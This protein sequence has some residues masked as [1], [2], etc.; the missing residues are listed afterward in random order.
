MNCYCIENNDK[1]LFC[2]ENVENKYIETLENWGGGSVSYFFKNVGDKYIKEFPNNFNNKEIN[3]ANF[4][5]YGES[6][7]KNGENWE[8]AL[9]VFAEQC[10]KE[11]IDWIILGSISETVR[12]INIIPHDIDIVVHEKDL[13]KI[14][15]VF[16]NY[17]IE[18][19]MD[20]KDSWVLQYFG[21]LCINGVII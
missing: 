17:F 6:L 10:F 16:L 9:E 15:S 13:N 12:G 18:P 2:L 14:K 1:F 11:N 21:R 7:F 3:G 5:K 4:Q 8:E 20:Y 19:I